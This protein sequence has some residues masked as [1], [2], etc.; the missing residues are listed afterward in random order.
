MAVAFF[1]LSVLVGSALTY[2]YF[3]IGNIWDS[4]SVFG[5]TASLVLAV[6]TPLILASI[7]VA[8]SI[9]FKRGDHVAFVSSVVLGIV[10]VFMLP[11]VGV[12]LACIFTGDCL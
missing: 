11:I 6:A 5:K 7:P 4:A 8:S 12:V 10:G 2:G 9:K 1:L 3:G